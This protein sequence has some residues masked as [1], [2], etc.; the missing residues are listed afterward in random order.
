M[1]KAYVPPDPDSPD[2]TKRDAF[3]HAV[4]RSVYFT[5][6]PV[7]RIYGEGNPGASNFRK[8]TRFYPTSTSYSAKVKPGRYAVIGPRMAG[9]IADSSGAVRAYTGTVQTTGLGCNTSGTDPVVDINTRRIVTT[10]HYKPDYTP[11]TGVGQ[12]AI[13]LNGSDN[14][15]DVTPP[16]RLANPLAFV[17]DGVQLVDSHTVAAKEFIDPN[18]ALNTRIAICRD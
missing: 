3:Y 2:K 1:R 18:L 8:L 17:I 9:F 5:K 13:Y 6:V 11:T 14:I 15:L 4:D 16:Q 12:V 10:P 7:D